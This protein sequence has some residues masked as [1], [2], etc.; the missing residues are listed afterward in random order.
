[1]GEP[2]ERDQHGDDENFFHFFL[3]KQVSMWNPETQS[4][5]LHAVSREARNMDVTFTGTWV[6]P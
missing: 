1:M 5:R 2:Y 4:G 6:A 3:P